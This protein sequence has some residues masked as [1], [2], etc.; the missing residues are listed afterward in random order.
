[1]RTIQDLTAAFGE[2]DI[3]QASGTVLTLPE[4]DGNPE[5]TQSY[6]LMIY[7]KL[8]ETANVHVTV[9]PTDRVA[10]SFQGKAVKEHA[11]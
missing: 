7:T 11:S 10:I 2:P 9:Y 1:M 6:P 5:T 4:R 8:S 3:K